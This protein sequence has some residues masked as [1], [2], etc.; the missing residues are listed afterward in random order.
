VK[1]VI[2]RIA[3]FSPLPPTRSGIA[4]YS[5]ELLPRL[6]QRVDLT[7]FVADPDRVIRSL[8]EQFSVRAIEEYPAMRWEYDMALYQVGNGKHHE[9]IYSTLLRYPGIT[10]LHE[11][12]LHHLIVDCTIGRGNS[13][14]YIREMGYGLG[15]EG[16][17]LARQVRCGQR[18]QP[19]FEVPLNER[20]LDSS[21]GVI[22]H[23][24]HVQQRIRER[25][26]HLPTV[27]VPA[28]IQ[29]YSSV[30]SR[31]DLGCPDKALILASA[32]QVTKQKQ[33][34]LALDAFARLRDEF[35]NAV[36]L[37]V[38]EEPGQDVDLNDWIQQHGLQNAVICTGYVH[39]V[40][41]FT[42]WIAAADVLV[43]LRYPTV[44]ETSATALRGLAA[45]R[46]VI[47]SNDGWYAEL[48]DDVCVKVLPNDADALLAA[49]RRLAS[50]ELL[51]REM[52]RRAA[53]YAYRQH[54]PDRVAQMYVDSIR[55]ILTNTTNWPKT[56]PGSGAENV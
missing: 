11:Y 50:D 39:D 36:Y 10:I 17:C 51:R 1:P 47:V 8:R 25:R 21:L 2:W 7:L 23:S 49:M 56:L 13:A 52:G 33:I 32:G 16:L 30:L 53:E 27:V 48:P 55:E 24:K 43:N 22:V 44:G 35:P 46:P 42:S 4:D 12:F 18:G 41:Q 40:Q 37:V 5:Y 34:I 26:P 29:N 9:G 3:Y 14:G 20:L 19:L 28:P 15:A 31:Q 38:G 45:G 6:A 54:D